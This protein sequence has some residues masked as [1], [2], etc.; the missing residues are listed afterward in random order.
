MKAEIISVGSEI[1]LGRIVDTNA[2]YLSRFVSDLGVEVV[3]QTS[4]PDVV[5]ELAGALEAATRRADIILITGG[6]GPT[7]DDVTREALAKMS[8][9]PLV[10]SPEA[11]TTLE[12]LFA[13]R[14]LEMP[15]S[16]LRQ[17]LLPD[18]ACVISN[19][20][21]S[22]PG[23]EMH[24]E[25]AVVFALP[26]V[27]GE[28]KPMFEEY[29]LRRVREM[30]GDAHAPHIREFRLF[31]VAEATIGEGLHE[32]M[33]PHSNPAVGTQ[34]S[35]GIITVRARATDEA[36]R[37]AEQLLD[38][39]EKEIRSRFGE[40]L[41]G[42]GE[43]VTLAENVVSLL[44]RCNRTLAVAESC[45]GGL[46]CDML[47]DVPGV[48]R[49]L[50]E[51]VVAYS[52]ESKVHELNV[53][54]NL[55]ESRGAVSEEAALAM[56]RGVRSR[57][58]ADIGLAVTGIAGPSGGSAAKPVGLVYIALDGDTYH[59]VRELRLFGGRRN[60]KDRAAKHLLNLLRVHLRECI[61]ERDKKD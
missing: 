33:D 35:G 21:G 25:H 28:M 57:S 8:G 30:L 39:V 6:L 59:Q 40:A 54:R 48:S 1:V 42:I 18:G 19:P 9:R 2:A 34:A 61:H 26:G 15:T 23:I 38:V 13:K 11:R 49:F 3:R 10:E 12:Q 16:N 20:L 14:G 27:P 60:I 17:A 37:K 24:V 55:I 41:F 53:P 50:L 44:E 4:A 45:T 31:G 36:G 7:R 29:V 5:E 32:F 56:A 22:A 47:T 46:V 58:G 43:V 51:G 52:N